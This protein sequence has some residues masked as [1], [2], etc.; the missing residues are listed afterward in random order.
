M[1]DPFMGSGTTLIEAQRLG[2]NSIGI[3]LQE[4]VITEAFS[5]ITQEQQS[6]TITRGYVGD[7]RNID[8]KNILAENNTKQ[9]QFVILHPPYWDILKFSDNTADLSNSKTLEEFL[10]SF[11]AVVDN[12]C[13]SLERN[14]YCAVVIGDKYANSEIVSLG[15][16]C[17][18]LMR[19]QGYKHK[20]TIVKNF[21]DTK[22]KANQQGIWRYRALSNDFYI[23]KHEYIFVFKKI[24]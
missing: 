9:V 8:I 11:G 10:D 3:E 22:G 20:A 16:Y 14:C 5:R 7:S 15:F 23:F 2:R 24:N 13:S 6:N 4:S 21:E 1:L 19:K 18:E 12:I 17:M